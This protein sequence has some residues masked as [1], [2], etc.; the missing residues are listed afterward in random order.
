MAF[1]YLTVQNGIQNFYDLSATIVVSILDFY[2]K[3][4]ILVNM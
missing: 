4:M 1:L 2:L 3:L